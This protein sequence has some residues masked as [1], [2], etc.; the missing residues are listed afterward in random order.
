MKVWAQVIAFPSLSAKQG[1]GL[2]KARQLL[3]G[4]VAPRFLR[5][6]MKAQARASAVRAHRFAVQP[7]K[8]NSFSRS[9]RV[10][11]TS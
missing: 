11:S 8:P 9:S 5:A 1:V 6:G 3:K 10:F 2:K 4:L 7:M